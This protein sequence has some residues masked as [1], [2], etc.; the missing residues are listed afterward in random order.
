[1][2]AVEFAAVCWDVATG[3]GLIDFTENDGIVLGAAFAADSSL[4]AV[5]R[6]N[7]VELWNPRKGKKLQSVSIASASGPLAFS[8]DGHTLAVACQKAVKF[9]DV[10]TGKLRDADDGHTD[11]IVALTFSQ[12]G[13]HLSS[14][15]AS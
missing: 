5:C 9:I 11:M 13:R 15:P 8:P 2:R 4:L 1:F 10:A 12:D 3:K 14:L 7:S 6:L